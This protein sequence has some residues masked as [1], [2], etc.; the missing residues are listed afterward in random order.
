MNQKNAD[1]KITA[2]VDQTETKLVWWIMHNEAEGQIGKMY[3][4]EDDNTELVKYVDN[5]KQRVGGTVILYTECHVR[6]KDA[7][8]EYT[9]KGL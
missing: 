5:A 8:D 9:Q 6:E 1:D 2:E 3:K 4:V 7:P